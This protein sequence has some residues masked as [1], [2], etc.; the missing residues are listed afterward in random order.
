MAETVL[1]SNVNT[2]HVHLE[3][4]SF[5]RERYFILYYD[6]NKISYQSMKTLYV[7]SVLEVTP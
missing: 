6:K 1:G 4:N 5:I 7:L 3:L 2:V